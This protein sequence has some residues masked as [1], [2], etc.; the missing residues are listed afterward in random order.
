M[1]Q[2]DNFTCLNLEYQG[3]KLWC[4]FE[5]ATEQVVHSSESKRDADKY[6]K[7]LER[8]GAFNGFTPSFMMIDTSIT[9]PLLP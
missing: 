8:G 2:R 6:K 5:F 7:F 4:I 9:K 1:N 3:K